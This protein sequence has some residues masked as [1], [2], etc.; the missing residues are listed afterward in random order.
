MTASF[1]SIAVPGTCGEETGGE[2][3]ARGWPGHRLWCLQK[4]KARGTSRLRGPFECEPGVLRCWAVPHPISGPSD[5]G[6]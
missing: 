3:A 1:L 4:E 6:R 2:W 5:S